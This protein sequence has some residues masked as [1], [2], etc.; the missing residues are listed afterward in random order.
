[1]GITNKED[2]KGYN[3]K[4]EFWCLECWK[5]KDLDSRSKP[6][7]LSEDNFIVQKDLDDNIV[8]CDCCG[9]RIE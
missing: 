1:M 2:I 8:I 9:K 4:G 6:E 3:M 7:N 5:W